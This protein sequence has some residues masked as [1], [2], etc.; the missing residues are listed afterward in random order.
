MTEV[1]QRRLGDQVV[2]ICD[3][4]VGLARRILTTLQVP[5]WHRPTW[6]PYSTA[7]DAFTSVTADSTT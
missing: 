2:G 6:G 4:P 1:M 7:T 5:G 3:S